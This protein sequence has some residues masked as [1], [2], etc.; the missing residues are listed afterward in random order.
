M[1]TASSCK[2]LERIFD[3]IACHHMSDLLMRRE[4]PLAKMVF[5]KRVP[6][7]TATSDGQWKARSVS[8]RGS[9]DQSICSFP[10]SS[11]ISLAR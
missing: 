2:R 6:N 4:R 10:A 7:T 9:T 8:P 11:R 1:W 5:A 3:Q